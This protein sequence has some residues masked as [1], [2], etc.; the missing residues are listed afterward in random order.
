MEILKFA[1]GRDRAS[2]KHHPDNYSRNC[3]VYTGTHDN[4]T[5]VGW[6]T[7]RPGRGGKGL[8]AERNRVLRT[9][10]TDGSEIHGDFIQ[11][12]V[13]SYLEAGDPGNKTPI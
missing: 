2:K 12:A 1:F 9:L 5:I 13:A 10:G 8:K 6:F 7:A 11:M 4:D 3:V